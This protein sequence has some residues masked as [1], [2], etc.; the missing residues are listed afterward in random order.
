MN[1]SDT[2]PHVSLPSP[3]ALLK[4]KTSTTTNRLIAT[5]LGILE[6]LGTEH[7]A[8]MHRLHE[9]LPADE[10]A[11]AELLNWFDEDKFLI[12]RNRV[13][14]AANDGKREMEETVDSLRL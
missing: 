12:L 9:A 5:F 3:A 13:L 8:A 1:G 6:E 11:Y 2:G 7:D 4:A 10:K 14:R